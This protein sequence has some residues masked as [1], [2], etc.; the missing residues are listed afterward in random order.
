M[1]KAGKAKAGMG[2]FKIPQD[3]NWLRSLFEIAAEDIGY[4]FHGLLVLGIST[5]PLA[6][7]QI[8]IRTPDDL[9]S[10]ER[11]IWVDPLDTWSGLNSR[12]EILHQG[13]V[14]NPGLQY[15]R[16]TTVGG[17][18]LNLPRNYLIAPRQEIVMR[19]TSL[20]AFGRPAWRYRV[21]GFI[22][23]EVVE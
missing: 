7:Q 9:S 1:A 15:V 19:W 21:K 8:V 18:H 14:E 13:R 4:E 16:P 2:G 22:A 17:F 12:F 23:A 10:I 6:V 3:L 11:E 20:T 5:G